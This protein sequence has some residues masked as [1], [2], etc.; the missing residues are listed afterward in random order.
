MNLTFATAGRVLSQLRGDHRTVALIIGLPCLL[1]GLIAWMFHDRPEVLDQ[2]GPMLV[3]LFPLTVMFLVTSVATLRERQSGTLERLMTT[4]IRRGDFVAGYGLAFATLAL[5]QAF[6]VVGFALLVGMDVAGPLWLVIVVALLD[7]ILGCTLGLAASALAR[8]E[9]QAVQMMPAIIFPQL[10][11]CGLLM[12]RDQM[13]QVLEWLSR[14]F[15]LTYAIEAMTS[16]AAGDEWVDIRG[17]VA[18]IALFIVGAVVL[19]VATLR[20]RTA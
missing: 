4:P 9:F 11:T 10:I 13:P 18:V 3:G 7:A 5:V 8:S 16:L 14:A 15:P 17:A 2:F 6:V 1:I 12:P 19:G 20:R